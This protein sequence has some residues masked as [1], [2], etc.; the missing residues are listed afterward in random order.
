MDLPLYTCVSSPLSDIDMSSFLSFNSAVVLDQIMRQSGD[1]PSQVLFRDI[2]L[3]LRNC[4]VTEADWRMLMT[5]TPL[6]ISDESHFD[7]AVH[8]FLTL[9]AVV[10]H[11]C[12][13]V[14]TLLL[15]LRLFILIKMHQ[16]P[17]LMM[18]VDCS[19]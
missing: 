10:E 14:I 2:L 8:L 11:N 19:L 3:R 12:I 6:Q 13:P 16:R 17:L 4:E 9:E 15:Q 1:D 7:N 5:R 18:L